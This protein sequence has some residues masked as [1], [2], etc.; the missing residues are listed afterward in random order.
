MWA[1]IFFKGILIGFLASIPLGPVGVVCIQ[2]TLSKSSRSGFVSGLGA[3]SAD[4]IFA[5]IAAFFL[6]VVLSFI[7]DYIDYIKVIGGISVIIVGMNIFLKNPVIQ[8]RKNRANKG[9]LWSDFISVFLLTLANP[10]FILMFVALFATFGVSTEGDGGAHLQ[11]GLLV[12]GVFAGAALWWL[13]LT[14][15]I[16]LL[17]KKF[18]PRH[19]LILNRI[20]G[21]LI[22]MLGAAAILSLFVEVS[23]VNNI[24]N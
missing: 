15:G 7:E 9:N 8:I 20:T 10:A 19:M 24:I 21:A 14:S 1:Q 3:A 13:T 23:L 12:S 4:L 11:G 16:S 5:T 2:R 18:R 17:R 6:S 22:V